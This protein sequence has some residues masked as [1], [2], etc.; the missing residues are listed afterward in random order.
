[1]NFTNV[2]AEKYAVLSGLLNN[3]VVIKEEFRLSDYDIANI[4]MD[5]PIY[6]RQYGAYF[7][8]YKLR[9]KDNN[10]S[11]VTLVKISTRR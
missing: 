11:E 10:T 9:Q 2:I 4:S 3:A 5:V 6:L 8:I 1:M 7:V